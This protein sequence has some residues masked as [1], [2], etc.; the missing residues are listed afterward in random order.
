MLTERPAAGT[1]ELE[2]YNTV[3][4]NPD[5]GPV[6]RDDR[7]RQ[8]RRILNEVAEQNPN[9]GTSAPVYIEGT[10]NATN[11][12]RNVDIGAEIQQG[13]PEDVR[14]EV[15]AVQNRARQEEG[16]VVILPRIEGDNIVFF[17]KQGRRRNDL[18]TVVFRSQ[19][20][21]QRGEAAP[22]SLPSRGQQQ[23]QEERGLQGGRREVAATPQAEG[24][25]LEERREA[26]KKKTR[27]SD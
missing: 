14:S 20:P 19:G 23:T 8:S 4:Q 17:D 18:G 22:A 21:A 11:G 2:I 24:P 9:A 6:L 13:L 25:T 16:D 3:T 5:L 1:Q 27:L 7:A 10:D 15:E 26:K 12:H